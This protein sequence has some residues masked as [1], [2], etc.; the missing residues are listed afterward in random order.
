MNRLL[1]SAFICVLSGPMCSAAGNYL[2]I[3]KAELAEVRRK[4]GTSE[5]ARDIH[6]NLIARADQALSRPLAFPGRGGQLPSAHPAQGTG[7]D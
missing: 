6:E 1:Q 2:L 5:W 7:A 4:A 3:S